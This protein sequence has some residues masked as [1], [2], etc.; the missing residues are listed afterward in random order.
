[1]PLG[2]NR[3]P[4]QPSRVEDRGCGCTYWG[5]E[6]VK[7]IILTFL[8]VL[9]VYVIFFIGTLIR[10][11]L[12]KYETIGM[13]P[14]MERTIMVTGIGRAL[15]SND[16]AMTTIGYSNTDKDVAK[17]QETNKSV[18]DK[19]MADLKKMGV[20]DKDLQSNY[21]IY[22]DYTYSQDKGQELKG[23]R[24][25]NQL[26]VK[27]RDLAKISEVL[28]LAGKYGANEVGGLSFTIDDPEN[29]KSV[30]R[31]KGLNDAKAKAE[32]LAKSLGMRLGSVVN[33]NEYVPDSGMYPYYK[34]ALNIG[35]AEGGGAP[36]AVASGS[37]DVTVNV[38]VTYEI[39]PY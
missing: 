8:G 37:R 6:F 5:G 23:Y 38:N 24:V 21:T 14:K 10:N 31:E 18:M 13:S 25:T 19:V 20:E 34:D 30:A 12:K 26:T 33:F 17:A 39:L 35:A 28:G 7:K 32:Y 22:P 3:T 11:N 36:A 15:G 16:I 1:M 4:P 27:I 29:L 2:L 9:L